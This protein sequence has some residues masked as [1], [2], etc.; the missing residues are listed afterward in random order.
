MKKIIYTLVALAFS[1]ATFAQIYMTKS[2]EFYPG[3]VFSK[4]SL[5]SSEVIKIG[6]VTHTLKIDSNSPS[7]YFDL[8]DGSKES[9]QKKL[10]EIYPQT[11]TNKQNNHSY[12]GTPQQYNEKGI[13]VLYNTDNALNQYYGIDKSSK[14]IY[15][16]TG[17]LLDYYLYMTIDEP[18]LTEKEKAKIESQSPVVITAIYFGKRADLLIES[19]QSRENI[20]IAFNIYKS[21]ETQRY[22]EADQILADA[23]LHILCFGKNHLDISNLNNQEIILAFIDFIKKPM[24]KDDYLT[25]ISYEAS[26]LD[27]LPYISDIK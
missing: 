8:Q 21:K 11:S 23:S 15:I 10:E 25:P 14:N 5:T 7:I 24:T 17:E 12:F 22:N 27:Y 1:S 13:N 19:N 16:A 6:N 18:F 20:T 4:K 9:W 3:A 26:Y 2:D